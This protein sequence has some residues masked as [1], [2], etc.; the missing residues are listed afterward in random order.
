MKSVAMKDIYQL[1]LLFYL[2]CI[3]KAA[4][5]DQL[6][7]R[8]ETPTYRHSTPIKQGRQLN[9]GTRHD[10]IWYSRRL[11]TPLVKALKP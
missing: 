9:K 6:Q 2:C 10:Q 8:K 11:D 4:V 7:S 5:Q 3:P 1:L